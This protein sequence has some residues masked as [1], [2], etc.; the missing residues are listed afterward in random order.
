MRRKLWFA[1]ERCELG[2]MSVVLQG[3]GCS[4]IL[5]G[6]VRRDD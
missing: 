2:F 3:A 6:S 5:R 1:E 4:E